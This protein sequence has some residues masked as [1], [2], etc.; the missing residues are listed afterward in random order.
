[1]KTRALLPLLLAAIALLTAC[2]GGGKS[3]AKVT[4]SLR[5]WQID[6]QP[7][8]VRPGKVEFT[9]TNAGSQTHQFVV[10]KSDLPPG[11][12]PTTANNTVDES[13]LNVAGSIVEIDP[14]V[15]ATLQLELFSGKY[16]FICNLISSGNAGGP[17]DP[18]YLNGMAASFFVLD[19]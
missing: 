6:T 18:H 10:V 3:A 14:G 8:E 7:V 2:S 17:A 5:E 4:V 15:T 12:L 11:Q 1:M 16:I 9:V 19:E 13:K